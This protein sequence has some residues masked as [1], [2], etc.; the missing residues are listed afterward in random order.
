VAILGELLAPSNGLLY[1]QEIEEK[2]SKERKM[3]K[4]VKR[5]RTKKR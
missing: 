2:G 3:I 5:M 4:N 1:A